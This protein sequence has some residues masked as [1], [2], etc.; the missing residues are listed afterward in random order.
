MDSFEISFSAVHDKS[1]VVKNI[2]TGAKP[3][4]ELK[5]AITQLQD[6]Y[7]KMHCKK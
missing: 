1:F 3:V 4:R 6:H 5:R 7:I 2:K